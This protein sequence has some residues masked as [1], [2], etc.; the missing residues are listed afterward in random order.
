MLCE[1]AMVLLAKAR[2]VVVDPA[3]FMHHFLSDI[4]YSQQS[5]LVHLHAALDVSEGVV[6]LMVGGVRVDLHECSGCIL[7]SGGGLHG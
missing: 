1:G 7:D 3:Q 2:Q 4:Q 6:E 5:W